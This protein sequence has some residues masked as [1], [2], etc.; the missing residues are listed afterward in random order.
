MD[1]LD[2]YEIRARIAPAALISLPIA[3]STIAVASVISDDLTQLIIGSGFFFIAFSYLLSFIIRHHG[4][5]LE[6]DLWI[7]WDGEPSTRFMRW[8]DLTIV[9]DLKQ[10]IYSAVEKYCGMALSTRDQE[11][12]DPEKADALIRQAFRNVK[13]VVRQEDPDG[14][15][16]KHNSE[17][18]FHRNLLGNRRL[19]LAF[20]IIGVIACGITFYF[21]NA[22]ILAF[23]L[24]LNIVLAIVSILGGWYYLPMMI[25]TTA[26]R[27]AESIWFSFLASSQK[28]S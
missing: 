12:N 4:K 1:W 17:Y 14:I 5:E 26:E 18:G 11:I 9:D 22:N 27:Y 25:K 10:Q 2:Q 20:S 6:K 19:W 15:W 8:R 7:S 13:A 21:S 23:G 24:A 3:V 16:A 28:T